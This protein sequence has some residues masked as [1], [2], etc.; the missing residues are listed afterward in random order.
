MGCWIQRAQRD[1]ASATSGPHHVPSRTPQHSSWTVW[2]RLIEKIAPFEAIFSITAKTPYVGLPSA[3]VLGTTRAQNRAV[4]HYFIGVCYHRLAR[5]VFVPLHAVQRR[6]SA[7]IIFTL[8]LLNGASI[9]DQNVT[10]NFRA[11]GSNFSEHWV[12]FCT[13]KNQLWAV[14]FC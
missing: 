13:A 12:H 11:V 10:T 9:P 7:G 8:G 4:K 1:A 14:H 5:L 3:A 6:T 2:F